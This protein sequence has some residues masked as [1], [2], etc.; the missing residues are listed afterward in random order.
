VIP[1]YNSFA[2]KKGSLRAT[3]QA[4]FRQ[5]LERF[6][7]VVVDDGSTD[8]TPAALDATAPPPHVE[9]SVARLPHSGNRGAVRNE[10]VRRLRADTI[11]FLDD[12]TLFLSDDG[13]RRLVAAS[14]PGAFACGAFR[15]WALVSWEPQDVA[16]RLAT[17]DYRGLADRSLASAQMGLSDDCGWKIDTSYLSNCGALARR[18]FDAAGGFDAERYGGWGMEDLDL[19]LRLLAGG[20]RFANVRNAVHVL[21][22][23]HAVDPGERAKKE[24]NVER[25]RR[26][27]R[28]LGVALDLKLLFTGDP[29]LALTRA[30]P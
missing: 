12:D 3:L 15:R 1:T 21:H 23:T 30:N 10:G 27:E 11:V 5:D 4:L 26:R 24:R 17:G 2:A 13:L 7:V 9:F 14:E 22:L 19:M 6:E 20:A 18:D 16:A 8:E 25:Y 28:E 29:A